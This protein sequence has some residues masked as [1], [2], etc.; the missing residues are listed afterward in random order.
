MLGHRLLG[1]ASHVFRSKRRREKGEKEGGGEYFD[2]LY[3]T[4]EKKV[5]LVEMMA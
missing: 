4:L 3:G 1:P 5:G 2:T